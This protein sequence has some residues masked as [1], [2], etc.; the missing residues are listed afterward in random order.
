[1]KVTRKQKLHEDRILTRLYALSVMQIGLNSFKIVNKGL[2]YCRD[3]ISLEGRQ[4]DGYHPG[5]V[6]H[7]TLP[8]PP[9]LRFLWPLTGHDRKYLRSHKMLTC[10]V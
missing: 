3:Q 1:M 7:S 8:P 10:A 5:Y 9:P 2:N 6:P 4:K